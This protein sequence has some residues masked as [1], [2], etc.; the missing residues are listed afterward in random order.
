MAYG[1]SPVSLLSDLLW[2]PRLRG[3]LSPISLHPL[4]WPQYHTHWDARMRWGHLWATAM[5]CLFRREQNTNRSVLHHSGCLE[6]TGEHTLGVCQTQLWGEE[7]GVVGR[8]RKKEG[9]RGR[10]PTQSV[11]GPPFFYETNLSTFNNSCVK[12]GR[13]PWLIM[14]RCH[15]ISTALFPE[16]SCVNIGNMVSH[17][18]EWILSAFLCAFA[19][20]VQYVLMHIDGLYT[21]WML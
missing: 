16:Q 4:P 14:K 1:W 17:L 9:W 20:T 21:N 12:S 3:E 19:C 7:S 18:S 10:P 15:Y 11:G 8:E 2:W 13:R 5:L 6:E